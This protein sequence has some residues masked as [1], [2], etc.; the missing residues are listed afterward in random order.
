MPAFAC[1][2]AGRFGLGGSALVPTPSDEPFCT[3]AVG[4]YERRRRHS[5]F[6]AITLDIAVFVIIVR[7]SRFETLEVSCTWRA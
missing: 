2:V 3:V 5:A 1:E 4:G 7:V 6:V